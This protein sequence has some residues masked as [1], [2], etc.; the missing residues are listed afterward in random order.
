MNVSKMIVLGIDEAG[1]GP[2]IGPMVVAGAATTEGKLRYLEK[3]ITR[4]SKGYSRSKREELFYIIKSRV[5]FIK[6]YLV[7]A[8]EI[9]K[10]ILNKHNQSKGLNNLEAFYY[11]KIILDALSIFKE[12]LAR[13]YV[14]SCDMDPDR[15]KSR[16]LNFLGKKYAKLKDNIIS[17]HRA[18]E[19]YCIVSIA[20][21]I[22]KVI[23]DREIERLKSIYGDFGS[24]Y[25][26]D[27]KTRKFI[28]EL[29]GKKGSCNI[30]RYSWKTIKRVRE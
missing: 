1:R 8:Q 6:Y 25:P 4:D 7:S 11:S 14:D 23:R 10:W 18:D 5:D 28:K 26:S 22:A 16:I 15:F 12:R 13:I 2:V 3:Y 27:P 20:S 17:E 30:V 9:D 21:I 19:K 24:G 29:I